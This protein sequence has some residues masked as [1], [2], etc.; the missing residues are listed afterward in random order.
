MFFKKLII[1]V[2]H[3]I[4]LSI[5]VYTRAEDSNKLLRNPENATTWVS[6]ISFKTKIQIY[7]NI[8]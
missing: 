3:L 2:I 6:H 8:F 5:A 4:F 7:V 1:S